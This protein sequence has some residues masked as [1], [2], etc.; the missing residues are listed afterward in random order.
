[1]LDNSVL[2]YILGGQA[3]ILL[4]VCLFLLLHI[5]KRKKFAQQ[6]E[7][8]INNLRITAGSIRQQAKQ[9]EA[10]IA[11][12]ESI[13]EKSY[14]DFID[15]EIAATK[16]HHNTLN[17]DRDIVLDIG[18]E[19]PIERQ[20]AS[21]RH[22]FLLA[23]KESTVASDDDTADWDILQAKLQQIIDFYHSQQPQV[24]DDE[25]ID[26]GSDVDEEE[27]REL[28]EQLEQKRARIENLERF[29]HLFF[30]MESKW[31]EAK[32]QAEDYH[33]QLLA[34]GKDLGAGEDFEALVNSYSSNF[35]QIQGL[36]TEGGSYESGG[37][38]SVTMEVNRTVIEAGKTVY[39]NQDEVDRLRNMAVDQH[40]IINELK[41]KLYEA[42]DAEMQQEVIEELTEQLS[43]QERFIQEAETCTKLLEE[44]LQRVIEENGQLREG[45][46]DSDQGSISDEDLERLQD[47]VS[48]L[49]GESKEMLSTIAGLEDENRDLQNQL[50]QLFENAADAGAQVSQAAAGGADTEELQ[51]KL[52]EVQQEL[53]NLQTQHIEL[54]ER[55]LELKMQSI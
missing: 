38:P 40:K 34:M 23:E 35:D 15:Q 39:A 11:Q 14:L 47:L 43:Q 30:N 52:S 18:Q 21:L 17:P 28:Q 13:P 55:Y 31:E 6:L 8:K 51:G 20:A 33:Q 10:R 7:D 44:E 45:G 48:D 2:V 36:I 12:L 41:K 54:E 42:A 50:Q 1:M 29:K 49:T 25:D 32:K 19:A 3:L 27:L 5:V 22:A 46:G 16:N 24:D 4:L 37:T 26:T 9:A 53:L